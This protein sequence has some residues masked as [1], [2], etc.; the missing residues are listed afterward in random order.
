MTLNQYLEFDEQEP[1]LF[2]RQGRFLLD[3]GNITDYLTQSSFL[4][5]PG[6]VIAVIGAIGSL[7]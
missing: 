4:Y 7:K 1:G 5:G 2:S 3:A 6:K